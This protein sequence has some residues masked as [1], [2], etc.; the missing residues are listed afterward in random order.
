MTKYIALSKAVKEG[1]IK[2][3]CYINYQPEVKSISL[4]YKETGII[5]AQAFKTEN[6][7]Y[8]FAC[9]DESQNFLIT[10]SAETKSEIM[11]D[12]KI[13]QKRCIKTLHKLCN[14]IYSNRK[15][16]ATAYCMRLDEFEKLHP[17]L[18]NAYTYWLASMSV[19]VKDEKTSYD[20]EGLYIARK[21]AIYAGRL[22]CIEQ[23]TSETE[24]KSVR[25]IIMLPSNILV[26]IEDPYFD[27]STPERA[28][29]IKA[30]M[31]FSK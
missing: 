13:H 18:K 21:D 19:E 23:F 31:K 4:T 1:K 28:L 7:Y 10:S 24:S 29:K 3:G 8:Q 5:T 15:L 27:G 17:T 26:N 9:I 11:F 30:N 20:W 25:P 2:P 22:Y 6:L 16:G 12:G 14:K